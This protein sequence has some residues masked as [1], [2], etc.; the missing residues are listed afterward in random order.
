MI[1]ASDCQSRLMGFSS[2]QWDLKGK[3]FED[4]RDDHDTGDRE[5]SICFLLRDSC[6]P[7]TPGP[8]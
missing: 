5:Y 7:P 8:F 3:C 2:N 4:L 1:L 6:L